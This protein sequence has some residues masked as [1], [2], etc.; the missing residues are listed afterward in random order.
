MVV[1]RSS[2]APWRATIAVGSPARAL[3]LPEEG[4][5]LR[6]VETRAA[7]VDDA[8]GHHLHLRTGI[9][10]QI[11]AA[12]HLINRVVVAKAVR[13]LLVATQAEAEA[14]AVDPTITRRLSSL[15]ETR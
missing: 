2:I 13:G 12:L 14:G 11:A 6:E 3:L 10:Q 15:L 4:P 7:P 1:N 8:V 9:E 5:E